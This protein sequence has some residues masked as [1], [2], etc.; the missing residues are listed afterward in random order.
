MISRMFYFLCENF[1]ADINGVCRAKHLIELVRQMTRMHPGFER[2]FSMCLP[3]LKRLHM[4]HDASPPS[5]VSIG[6]D[7][8]DIVVFQLSKAAH[9]AA[10]YHPFPQP[11]QSFRFSILQISEQVQTELGVF[12]M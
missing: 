1:Q 2:R 6:D 11:S 5:V 4:G 3:Y 10:N 8:Y 7:E 9:M 12:P